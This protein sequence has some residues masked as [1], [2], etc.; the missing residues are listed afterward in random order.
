MDT[1]NPF[2][3]LSLIVA[4]AILTNAASVLTMSTS[5][6]LA[7]AV[8]RARELSKQL[9]ADSIGPEAPRRMTE[10][11]ATEQRALLLLRALRGFY[12]ALGGF[13]SAALL[14]LLGA[15]LV[16]FEAP[17]IVGPLEV[18]GVTAGLAAVGAIVH[19]SAL[20]V[21]ETQLAVT[22]LSERV[23]RVRAQMPPET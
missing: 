14:S 16:P 21:R 18:L 1:P 17:V 23:T 5:N 2:A 15:L 19:G 3:V 11:S 22:V 10:L 7:R 9:E 20:L 6:R 12:F 8:D 13:A 4:P